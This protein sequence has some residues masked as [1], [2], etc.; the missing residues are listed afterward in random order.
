MGE[1]L[2]LD[3]KDQVTCP[4]SPR[5][6]GIRDGIDLD[7]STISFSDMNSFLVPDLAACFP[8]LIPQDFLLFQGAYCLLFSNMSWSL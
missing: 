2:E 5:A 6:G 8:P 3:W 1:V 4:R 7:G